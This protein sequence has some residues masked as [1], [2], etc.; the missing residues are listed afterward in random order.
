MSQ[1]KQYIV[2]MDTLVKAYSP[3]AIST[4]YQFDS[5]YSIDKDSSDADLAKTRT[6]HKVAENKALTNSIGYV[7]KANT[8]TKGGSS[9]S[10]PSVLNTLDLDKPALIL[11]DFEADGLKLPSKEYQKPLNRIF[12][13]GLCISVV[14]MKGAYSGTLYNYLNDGD[15]YAYGT[16]G[17][18]AKP[19]TKTYP[20]QYRAR[21]FYA[22]IVGTG[23]QCANLSN[24]IMSLT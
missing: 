20:N 24:S 1:K 10:L 12:K 22:V 23:A 21:S 2:T 16:D 18:N 9:S 7:S 17:N 19:M 3:N 6:T 15:D 13:K 5:Q 11:T 14:A 4:F 8:I